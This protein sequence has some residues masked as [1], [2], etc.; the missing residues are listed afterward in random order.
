LAVFA[1]FGNAVCRYFALMALGAVVGRDLRGNG[2][3]G[4]AG[5]RQEIRLV[6]PWLWGASNRGSV[7]RLILA[8]GDRKQLAIG[9]GDWAWAAAFGLDTRA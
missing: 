6:R 8:P 2:L 3:L 9:N 1:V 5:A 7:L 4:L